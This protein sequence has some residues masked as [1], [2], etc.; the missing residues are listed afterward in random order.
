M[1]VVIQGLLATAA[2]VG[3]LLLMM[4]FCVWFFKDRNASA[5]VADERFVHVPRGE[6]AAILSLNQTE[7]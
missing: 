7:Q 4:A 2:T 3:V 5:K 1:A 6:Y